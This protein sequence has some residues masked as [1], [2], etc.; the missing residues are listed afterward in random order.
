MGINHLNV[1]LVEDDQNVSN[2]VRNMLMEMGVS[3]VYDAEDGKGA[4]ELLREAPED[5]SLVICDWNMPNVT[6][7]EVLDAIRETNPELPFLMITARADRDSVLE[8]KKYNV[9]AYI[10]KPFSYGELRK[11]VDYAISRW[12]INDGERS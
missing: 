10:C 1:L 4:L 5:I 8:A 12:V 7:I 6:G 9:S 2:T 3:N 11:K